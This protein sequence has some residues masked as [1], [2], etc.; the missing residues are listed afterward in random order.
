MCASDGGRGERDRTASLPEL[1]RSVKTRGEGSVSESKGVRKERLF[2]GTK[3][4]KRV[5]AEGGASK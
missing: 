2:L 1:D 5:K 3:N 4:I